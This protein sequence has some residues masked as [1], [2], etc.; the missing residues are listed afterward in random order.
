[1]MSARRLEPA[2]RAGPDAISWLTCALLA[3]LALATGA[4]AAS[5]PPLCA[6]TFVVEGAPLVPGGGSGADAIVIV[7]GRVAIASGCAAVPALLRRHGGGFSATAVWR[8]G[9][10][11]DVPGLAFLRAR[12]DDSCRVLGGVF[13]ARASGLRRAFRATRQPECGDGLLDPNEQCDDA[14]RACCSATCTSTGAQG[15]AAPQACTGAA[16]CARGEFCALESGACAGADAAGT[17]EV[18]PRICTRQLDPVCGCDGRTWPNDCVRQSRGIAL[19]HAGPCACPPLACPRPAHPEDLDHD[20]CA[21]TCVPCPI[22]DC[23]PGG[24]PSDTDGD[25]CQESCAPSSCGPNRACSDM[26]FC[27]RPDGACDEPGFCRWNGFDVT[28][29]AVYDPVCGCDGKTWSNRCAANAAGTSVA[30]L[31]ECTSR[32]CGGIAGFPCAAGELCDPPAGTCGSADLFG[33]CTPQPQAC[34]DVWLP[35]CGCDGQTYGN[36]CD[37]QMAGAALDHD[38]PCARA[39]TEACDCYVPPITWDNEPCA[40]MCPMCGDYF[41]CEAGRCIEHCGPMP[42]EVATCPAS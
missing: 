12:A 30:S 32:T 42:I 22:V 29:T 18:R 35:V 31:G 9:C 21:E 5:D 38:G 26:T 4:R 17:C 16:P 36:D 25:G 37:R 8:R 1:M 14:D 15:C 40:M 24:I 34:P 23:L 33:T 7:D 19:D 13:H 20:G 41:Q 10:G 39:C 3:T 27:E 2:G 11:D 6:G 28:C